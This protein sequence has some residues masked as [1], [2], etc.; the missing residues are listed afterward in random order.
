MYKQLSPTL[1]VAISYITVPMVY[2]DIRYLSNTISIKHNND[3]SHERT[4]EMFARHFKSYMYVSIDNNS[5]T[6]FHTRA[7]RLTREV[8][9]TVNVKFVHRTWFQHGFLVEKCRWDANVNLLYYIYIPVY[10]CHFTVGDDFEL[11]IVSNPMYIES[12]K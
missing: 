2:I 9:T 10:H 4:A 1:C 12:L 6:I 8:F 5:T 3:E 11:R 7:G